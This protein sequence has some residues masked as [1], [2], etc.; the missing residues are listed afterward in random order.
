MKVEGWP[1]L[2]RIV[3]DGHTQE[4]SMELEVARRFDTPFQQED[5]SVASELFRNEPFD[6]TDPMRFIVRAEEPSVRR[7]RDISP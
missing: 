1:P 4:K 2:H 3:F 6:M 5:L 7:W